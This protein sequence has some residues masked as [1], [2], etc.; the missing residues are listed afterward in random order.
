MSL[1]DK[2]VGYRD[3]YEYGYRNGVLTGQIQARRNV[4]R[5]QAES[6]RRLALLTV[7]QVGWTDTVKYLNDIR[8]DLDAAT[9]APGRGKQQ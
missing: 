9:R 2:T 1:K 4:R 6:L 3:G 8:S 7:S 5:A